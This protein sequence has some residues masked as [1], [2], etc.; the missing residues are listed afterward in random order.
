MMGNQNKKNNK[1]ILRNT[2]FMAIR[3]VL[4][5]GISLYTS[6]VVLQ[7][8]GVEDYGIYNVVAGF[9]SMFAFLNSSMTNANQ[10]FYNI[11]LGKD[12]DTGVNVVY[13][14]SLRIQVF[15]AIAVLLLTETVGLW[16]LYDKMVIPPDRLDAAFWV[17]QFSV[18]SLLFIIFQIPYSAAIIAYERMDYYA[19]VGIIDAFLKLFIALS[20]PYAKGDQ[21][22]VYGFLLLTINIINWCLYFFYAKLHFKVLSFHKKFNFDLFKNML[23]FSAWNCFGIFSTVFREQGANMLLN[24]FFGPVINAARAIAYQVSGALESFVLN[25]TTASRPQM[26]QTYAKGERERMFHIM[27][28]VSKLCFLFVLCIALPIII[29]VDFVLK[30]WLGDTIP[31]HTNSFMVL[32]VIAALI[33]V[34]HP[35]TSH[36]VH[37]TGKMSVFQVTNGILNLLLIPIVYVM[38]RLGYSPESIF[39]LFIIM[40]MVI[41]YVSWIILRRLVPEFSIASYIRQVIIPLCIISVL[42]VILPYVAHIEMDSGFMRFFI[43]TLLSVASIITLGFLIALNHS[44]KRT[45]VGYL[46]KIRKR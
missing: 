13:N 28:S 10:R 33:R 14:T 31:E 26:I 36:I 20:I 2:I 30:I 16:Y 6:R 27:Y 35:M 22:I 1:I 19:Y 12:S 42:A 11:E 45:I 7:V 29:E 5:L 34:F 18:I 21:L 38:L 25:I 8:L 40:N 4:L 9:V 46:E 24:L 43:V 41:Q 37:A 39:V 44:E 17:F 32:V 3:M 23:G 15:L